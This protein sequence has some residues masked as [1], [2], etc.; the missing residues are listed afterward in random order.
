MLRVAMVGSLVQGLVKLVK[1]GWIMASMPLTSVAATRLHH[2]RVV[3]DPFRCVLESQFAQICGQIDFKSQL[4][5]GI[6]TI[7]L[8]AVQ[9]D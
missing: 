6:R 4:A 7:I 2:A 3:Y 1:T 8:L 9:G 5:S